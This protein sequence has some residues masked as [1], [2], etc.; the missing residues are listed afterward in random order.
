MSSSNNPR[1]QVPVAIVG[2]ACRAPGGVTDADGLWRLLLDERDAV[3]GSG[4]GRRWEEHERV[5]PHDLADSGTLRNGAFLDGIELFDPAFF[6]IPAKDAS[7]VDPQHRLLMETGWEAL[8]NAGIAPRSLKGSLTGLFVGISNTDYAKRFKLTEVDIYQG[9]SAV[10][11]GAPGRI[12]YFLDVNGP[13]LAVDAACAS[14]LVAVHLACRSLHDGEADLALAGGVTVQ[15]EWAG[16][17]GFARAGALSSRGRCAAFD[18]SADGFV[19]GEG[20]GM[21]VLKRLPDALRDGDR[22]LA[23]I[24]GTA[25][26]HAGRVQGITQP[27]R[28]AQRA[29]LA[30]ALR[31]AGVTPGDVRYVETHGTGTPVGDP[32]EF[33]A[34]DDVYGTGGDPC[35]LGSLKTNIG[36]PESAAGVLGLIKAA[37]AA[38]TGLIPANLHFRRWNPAVKADGTR[39]F[40]PTRATPWED[41]AGP[42]RAGVSAFG[43]TGANAHVIVEQPP[44]RAPRRSRP[45]PPARTRVYAVSAATPG[46]LT[47]TCARLAESLDAAGPAQP[48]LEDVAHTL[49]VRRSHLPHRA[50]VLAAGRDDLLA[51][52]RALAG[53]RHDDR[54][55]RGTAVLS[56]DPVWVFSGHGSQW[57]GMARTLLGRE[58]AFTEMIDRLD[59]IVTAE[60]GFS[61]R[62]RLAEGACGDRMDEVQPLVYAVQAGL[63]AMWRGWGVRPA[64][65]VGHSMGEAA[66]AVAAGVL[67]PEDGM[68]AIVIRSAM[69]QRVAGGGMVSVAL[70]A[71]RVAAEIDGLD[72]VS[73]AVVTAPSS[74][75]VAGHAETV[76]ELMA[77]WQERGVLCKRISVVVAAHSPQ[78]EPILGDLAERMSWLAGAPPEVPF[79]STS[80][81]PRRPFVFD[82][83]YWTANLRNPVRFDLAC[84]ALIEDGRRLFLEVSP[85]PL[86]IPAVEE[87]AAALRVPVI[88]TPSLAR[89]RDARAAMCASAAALHLAGAPVD[90]DAVNGGGA[91]A[92][93]PPTAF[94][95]A[96]FWEPSGRNGARAGHMWLGERVAVRDPDADDRTRHVWEADL[97]TERV[98]W[99]GQH[100]LHDSPVVPGAAYVELVLAA[101]AEL[102]ECPLGRTRVADVRFERLLPL[103]D[104]VPVQVSAANVG[105][106]VR[107][108]ISRRQGGAWELIASAHVTRA[109]QGPGDRPPLAPPEGGARDLARVYAALARMG[110]NTGPAFHSITEVAADGVT[111][112]RVPDEAVIR[113]AAPRVHPALLDGC[114]LSAAI[115]LIDGDGEP[116]PG[117]PWLPERVGAIVLPDD[118]RLIARVRPE[119]RREGEDVATGR[120]DLYAEDGRW[121]GALEGLRFVRAARRS[122]A[123]RLNGKLVEI[124]WREVEAPPAADRPALG[125]VA[126]IGEPGDPG[127]TAERL[128]KALSGRAESV[129]ICT[130]YNDLDPDA[131]TVVWC[132]TGRLDALDRVSKVVA[133]LGA[134]A[135]RGGSPRLWL[136]SR[137]ARQVLADDPVDPGACALRGLLRVAS[138]EQPEAAVS[139]V[140]ADDDA[141]IAAEVLAGDVETEVAWRAGRRHVARLVPAPLGPRPV[142]PERV[143]EVVAGRE[144]YALRAEPGKGLDGVRL[145]ATG[146]PPPEPGPGQVL[147]RVEAVT[148]HFRDV[149]IAL[150][151]YPS[152]N[153]STPELG[154]DATGVVVAAGDGVEDLRPGDRITALVPHGTGS[155]ASHC[156]VHAGLALPLPPGAD[157]AAFAPVAATYGTVW[158]SLVDV[159]R[160]AGGETVLVHSAAGGI[161]Q[162]ALAV[163]RLRGAT[164]IATA[165]TEEKR[166]HLREQGVEHVFDSRSLGFADEVRR[167]TGGRGVDVVLNSL[168][169]AAMRASLTLLAPGGRFVEIGKRDLYEGARVDLSTFRRGNTYA[170]VD[171]A[172]IGIE[173]P[174]VIREAARRAIAEIGAGRLPLPD[175]TAFP[176]A[177]APAAIKR[178][179]SGDHIGR[180]VLTFPEPGRRLGVLAPEREDVVRPGGAYVVT[181]GTRG[182]GLEAARWL[183]EAGAGRVVLGGRGEPGAR[184]SRTVAALRAGGC[185]VELVRGDIADPATA[186]RLVAA[187]GEDL[188]GVLHT[189]VVLDDAPLSALTPE[190]VARV[191][192]PKVAGA[193]NLHEA[194]VGADLD[195][196]AVFSSMAALLG[197]PGQANYAAAGAWVD[198]FAQW[199]QRR[200][201]RTLSVDWGAW[202][203]A[204]RATDFAERGFDTIATAEGFAA[205]GELLRHGRVNTGVFTYQPEVMF[206]LF[207]AAGR[208]PLL[209]EL[210]GGAAGPEVPADAS[211]V[212]AHPPG[213]ARTQL[214]QD[215]VVRT[216]AALLGADPATVPANAMFTD[217]GLDSLLA[218]AL[219]HRLHQALDVTL[220]PAA[221]WA[222]PTAARLA[223]HLD[224]ALAQER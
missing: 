209:A 165:G 172:L 88:T 98:A 188:R 215:V 62:R 137:L 1:R 138:F 29:V 143:V 36:H 124:A 96:R 114:V 107:V 199:R 21:V 202:G 23:L 117:R 110:L 70:P 86:L 17:V 26:N 210:G 182:L 93:L 206:R 167:V 76:R 47:R 186:R 205:L 16:N 78:V 72:G 159:A 153:G 161:G 123:Q 56:D 169:G 104:R 28:A 122:R 69:L 180:I 179:A 219:V 8:E 91:P 207:P 156:L 58:P 189:A 115:G 218:V 71:D 11:S 108:E 43:V 9:I 204:G 177:E 136:A 67:S 129:T 139:W 84:R 4:P 200:G 125:P 128:A 5:V 157:P 75:V 65:V 166:N 90:L 118:P 112:V 132:A 145:V 102:L 35:A 131:E 38:H 109:E 185:E 176:L 87:T 212:R 187:A 147:M 221:V 46:G 40:V 3:A 31:V 37:T 181:G 45:A 15:L 41:A 133:L 101:A 49:A 168:S 192:H 163:A 33:A 100:V 198:A 83:A 80:E 217:I 12:S 208:A 77:R 223:A 151:V 60:A 126:V 82:A 20:C 220:A 34:I 197:N 44:P 194:T 81:D 14:S 135:R 74:T 144:E 64:A 175:V 6:G 24:T 59:P 19:R 148:V 113:A 2:T 111:R 140:D 134:C 173:R 52:L 73:V 222:H 94:D 51:G 105:E 39:F 32:I 61:L 103:A 79:Y 18:A 116:G 190:R 149:M 95:R 141:G 119:V 196:F 13:S 99:L 201:L 191:W 53:E 224:D 158:H 7:S 203:E 121:L 211:A 184:E 22:I 127:H 30:A 63:T 92:V 142:R 85:H 50:C 174:A 120:A 164:V 55:V 25:I 154:S 155:I 178:L 213:P 97:G 150:G 216:L 160:L 57:P 193:L 171:I 27:S 89:D 162:A 152:E 183:A 48:A 170:A 146:E 54:A 42:R 66:A 10:P 68:R 106:R 214:V 195:W 130:P